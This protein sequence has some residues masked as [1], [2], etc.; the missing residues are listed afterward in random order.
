L[1]PPL[2]R[3]DSVQRDKLQASVG[4]GHPWLKLSYK[5][6]FAAPSI[7]KEKAASK[8]EAASADKDLT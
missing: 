2:R 6:F 7:T 5:A 3:F 4:S 8:F 1:K